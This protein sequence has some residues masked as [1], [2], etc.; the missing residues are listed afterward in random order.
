MGDVIRLQ[1]DALPSRLKKGGKAQRLSLGEG[2]YL[3]HHTAFIYD[4]ATKLLG[5]EVKPAAAGL[6]KLAYL[7]SQIAKHPQCQALPVLYQAEMNRLAGTKN[8][9]LS[10]KVA[11]PASLDAFDPELRSLRDNIKYIR[12]MVDGAYIHVS[13]GAGPRKD[14]L[15]GEGLMKTIG[16]LL[17]ERDAKR[18]KVRSVKVKQPHE[19]E[20]ILD[21]LNAQ[22]KDTLVLELSGD[23]EKDWVLRENFLKSALARAVKHVNIEGK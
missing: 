15:A 13:I 9:V 23:P 8:G 1:A 2:E 16:W 6:V 14:G 18:G 17:G 10:F 19:A 20:P 5:F 3:G 4:P 21:F 7:V 12:D 22:F 11:D